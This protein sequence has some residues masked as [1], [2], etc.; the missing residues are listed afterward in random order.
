MKTCSHCLERWLDM[1]L[2]DGVSALPKGRQEPTTMAVPL[3]GKLNRIQ[4]DRV[5]SHLPELTQLEDILISCVA[6]R[7]CLYRGALDT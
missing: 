5:P 1:K 3:Y 7:P 2:E 4:P 6:A